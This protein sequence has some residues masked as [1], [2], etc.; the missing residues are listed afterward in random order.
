MAQNFGNKFPQCCACVA[1]VF[2]VVIW[3]HVASRK[4]SAMIF[5]SVGLFDIAVHVAISLIW[6]MIKHW[7]ILG[8]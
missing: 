4:Q 6:G 1:L 7:A 8:E 2:R 5:W 3:G